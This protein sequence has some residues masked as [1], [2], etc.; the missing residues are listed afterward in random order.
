VVLPG[1]GAGEEVNADAHDGAE[2]GEA[3]GEFSGAGVAGN[4]LEGKG[5]KAGDAGAEQGVAKQER[6]AVLWGEHGAGHGGEAEQVT[7]DDDMAEVEGLLQ[8]GEKADGA[9]DEPE[10]AGQEASGEQGGQAER[11]ELDGLDEEARPGGGLSNGED[12]GTVS[13]E[14]GGNRDGC[15]GGGKGLIGGGGAGG[16]GPIG[17]L[18]LKPE[19]GREAEGEGEASSPEGVA[20]ERGD[21]GIE[22][23]GFTEA[24][25]GHGF[26]QEGGIGTGGAFFLDGRDGAV[27]AG[28]GNAGG[29]TLEGIGKQESGEALGENG[30]ADGEGEEDEP[31]CAGKT[32]AAAAQVEV[33]GEGGD[34]AA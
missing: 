12:F 26:E 17:E 9:D 28:E 7:G 14:G 19:A 27:Q 11:A 5:N 1:E 23:E 20:G 21:E 10:D 29:G 4:D 33:D 2:Q 32:A 22:R 15:R 16:V 34:G 30:K 25:T 24:E 18:T 3:V 8:A 6:E 13:G 31:G